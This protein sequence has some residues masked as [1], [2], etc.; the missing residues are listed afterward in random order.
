MTRIGFT[1]GVWDLL[2]KGHTN[3]FDACYNYCNY[4]I[5]GIMN[6]YWVRVQKGHSG[7]PVQS[8]QLRVEKLRSIQKINKIVVLDTLD[9]TQYLQMVDVWIKGKEQKNMRPEDFAN[10]IYID[11]TPEIS[12]TEIINKAETQT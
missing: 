9:M 5:V 7:R 1:V 8:L 11:R 2:H 12:T 6:D 4:L 10:C 3:F